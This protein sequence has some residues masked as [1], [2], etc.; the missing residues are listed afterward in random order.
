MCRCD[1]LVPYIIYTVWFR[2][3]FELIAERSGTQKQVKL[4]LEHGNCRYKIE[5]LHVPEHRN[6]IQN[7]GSAKW[8]YFCYYRHVESY[9]ILDMILVYICTAISFHSSFTV[10]VRNCCLANSR[11]TRHRRR[12]DWRKWAHEGAS[13]WD[14][15]HTGNKILLLFMISYKNKSPSILLNLPLSTNNVCWFVYFF[16]S[17]SS[18]QLSPSVL[19]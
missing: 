12:L 1:D 5:A 13:I 18:R 4:A 9:K 16:Q 19:E 15:Q 17:N 8:F 10:S 2:I 6:D 11:K 7:F 3:N 14:W